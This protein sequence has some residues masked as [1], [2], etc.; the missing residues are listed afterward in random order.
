MM[1]YAHTAKIAHSKAGAAVE[2]AKAQAVAV[3]NEQSQK[4]WNEK[5]LKMAQQNLVNARNNKDYSKAKEAG[6]KVRMKTVAKAEKTATMQRPTIVVPKKPMSP[7]KEVKMKKG[8]AASEAAWKS[9]KRAQARAEEA[10]NMAKKNLAVA[11]KA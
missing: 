6:D 3:T 9:T 8:V 1:N 2:A 7:E 11:M 4:A 5:Q 10:K